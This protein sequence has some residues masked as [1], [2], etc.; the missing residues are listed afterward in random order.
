[1]TKKLSVWG[2][3]FE[4]EV[5]FDRYKG[6]ENLKHQEDALENFLALSHLTDTAKDEVEKYC[7]DMDSEEIGTHIENIFKYVIPA[8]IFIKRTKDEK[9]VVSLMCN[10]RFDVEHGIAIVFENEKF[11]FVGNQQSI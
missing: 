11:S 2:R 4:L 1:M 7:L 8:F 3:E 5:V 9:R 10:Y 6:E